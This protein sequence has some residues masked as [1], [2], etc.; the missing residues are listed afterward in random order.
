MR[1]AQQPSESKVA[2]VHPPIEFVSILTTLLFSRRQ[3]VQNLA[4]VGLVGTSLLAG[5]ATSPGMKLHETRDPASASVSA[6]CGGAPCK[7]TALKKGGVF[8]YSLPISPVTLN[9]LTSHDNYSVDVM[10]WIVETLLVRDPLTY[11][12]RPM[13]ADSFT[14]NLAE[15]TV[16]FHLRKGVK[17]HDGS[18]MTGDDVKFSFDVYAQNLFD[19]AAENAERSD[20][21][22]VDLVDRQTIRVTFKNS[23]FFNFEHVALTPILPKSVYSDKIKAKALNK[24]VVATGPYRI[25]SYVVGEAINLKA[26]PDW[27]GRKLPEYAD[28]YNFDRIIV[29]IVNDENTNLLMLEKGDL[30]YSLLKAESFEM[31]EKSA[32]PSLTKTNV[33]VENRSKAIATTQTSIFLN[34]RRPLFHDQLTRSALQMLLNR[35]LISAKMLGGAMIP[36]TGPWHRLSEYADPSVEPV[37][38]SPDKADRLLREAG[39]RDRAGDGRLSKI[40]DGKETEFNFTIMIPRASWQKYL[41]YYQ[42]E[43]RKHGIHLEIKLVDWV[44]MLKRLDEL[45]FDAYVIGRGWP[46]VVDF[47]PAG[48]WMSKFR[49]KGQGN[50]SGYSSSIVDELLTKCQIEPDRKKRIRLLRA[51]Y[52]QIASDQSQLFWFSTPTEHYV[53]SRRLQSELPFL[54]YTLGWQ[55]WWLAD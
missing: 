25:D 36:A 23:K 46:G 13:L 30:D 48:E 18:E 53:R 21:A 49:G 33:I 35:N 40:I 50:V 42:S 43:L 20:I 6:D 2:Q 54:P 19:T 15:R 29:K 28:S 1:K 17:F 14:E 26:N 3:G 41:T 10:P 12:W 51:A 27:W 47:D 8:R 4:L 16:V 11:Q 38:F 37:P 45:D 24:S 39:W 5:C 32:G 34:L 44:L 9:P 22:R 52:R 7:R 55:K 31:L